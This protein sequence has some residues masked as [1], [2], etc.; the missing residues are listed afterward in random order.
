VQSIL[1]FKTL[2]DIIQCANQSNF[3]LAAG[4][5]TNNINDAMKFAHSIQA[6]SVWVNTYDA[7]TPQTPFGGYKQSG[8]GRE[9]GMDGLKPYL[10]VKKCFCET[11]SQILRYIHVYTIFMN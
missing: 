9:L 10:E 11:S 8:I 6:G 1:K 7:V 3:G 2:D 5:F 4:I